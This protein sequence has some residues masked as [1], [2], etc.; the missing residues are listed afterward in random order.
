MLIGK[1]T[2]LKHKY[3]RW[4]AV[5]AVEKGCT[6][7]GVNLDGSRQFVAATFPPIIKDIGALFVPFSPAVV[8]YALEHYAMHESGNY[9]YK[10][11]VYRA[12]GYDV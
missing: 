12:L 6:I 8:A 3:V 5:V 1:D 4:E 9:L 7:V 2:R 11:S 10:D